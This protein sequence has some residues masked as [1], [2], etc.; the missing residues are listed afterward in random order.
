MLYSYQI[1]TFCDAS[2]K[3]YAAAVY[4]RI[5]SQDLI[6]VNV[7][8]SKTRLAPCDLGKKRKIKSKQ[9]SL[10]RLELLAVL[11]GTR[12]TS[13]VTKES[14]LCVHK[15]MIF[16]NSHCVLYWLKSNNLLPVFV[17]NRVNK[18]CQEKQLWVYTIR[19]ES[20]R[21]CNKRTCRSE[22]R[23]SKLWWHGSMWLQ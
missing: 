23:Q 6:Q 19:G 10:P 14:K 1:L 12:V 13:Y 16:T 17:Q 22:I 18:I 8:F 20:C 2:T 15:R 9:L 7:V 4:L 3:S 5:A 21:F 11:I